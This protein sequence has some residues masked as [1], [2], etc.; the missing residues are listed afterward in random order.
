MTFDNKDRISEL[1]ITVKKAKAVF[2]AFHNA[3]VAPID[4]KTVLLAIDNQF[5][6]YQYL[7]ATL[8]D[9]LYSAEEQIKE[10]DSETDKEQITET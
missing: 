3:F 8:S 5:D 7:S 10:L 9:L 2:N 4:R 6:N 1:E